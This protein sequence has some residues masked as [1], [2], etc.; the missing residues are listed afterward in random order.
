MDTDLSGYELPSGLSEDGERHGLS[1]LREL[2]RLQG[3]RVAYTGSLSYYPHK[4]RQ[5]R[6]P[7]G[8]AGDTAK[9][10]LRLGGRSK[11]RSALP[12]VGNRDGSH[13]SDDLD[14]SVGGGW[15][16]GGNS[17]H[18]EAKPT[19]Y[20]TDAERQ[21]EHWKE[22]MPQLKADYLA[23][24]ATL[25]ARMNSS[26]AAARELVQALANQGGW[27]C[28]VC[29]VA[30]RILPLNIATEE[31]GMPN[32]P[33]DAS[34]EHLDALAT[35]MGGVSIVES[36]HGSR[37]VGGSAC[38]VAPAG[39]AGHSGIQDAELDW[40]AAGWKPVLDLHP[41]VEVTYIC[42]AGARNI[43]VPHLRCPTCRQ[44]CLLMLNSPCILERR[45]LYLM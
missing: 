20:A 15:C 32:A 35:T 4:A 37:A 6:A 28:H 25:S 5:Q 45:C 14:D 9:A 39:H 3:V 33:K 40:H 24:V 22:I 36:A 16:S 11:K 23:G 18:E 12:I 44:V 42:W 38:D 30:D 26:A 1:L 13:G 19:Q 29:P 34:S 10:G 31:G 7:R 43:S 8:P 21:H 2:E 17:D 41:V 27:R